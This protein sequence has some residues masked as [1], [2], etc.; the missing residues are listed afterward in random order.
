MIR[1][2]WTHRNL[3][4]LV[5]LLALW[6]SPLN[7]EAFDKQ[8][9]RYCLTP[10]EV[11]ALVRAEQEGWLLREKVTILEERLKLAERELALKDQEIAL[12][13]KRADFEADQ[14]KRERETREFESKQLREIIKVK[15]S[16]P[17]WG[18]YV[19][20][21]LLGVIGGFFLTR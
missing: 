20:S 11:E 17:V 6:L 19:L 5:I 12:E 21:G 18:D 2:C 16:K 4:L 13:K 9:D 10:P 3:F 7:A 15:D 1:S 14:F 8:G